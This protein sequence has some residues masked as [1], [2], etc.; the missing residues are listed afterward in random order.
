MEH[1]KRKSVVKINDVKDE[2]L[3]A[4]VSIEKTDEIGLN[5][6]IRNAKN[7]KEAVAVIRKCEELSKKQDK[8]I[9]NIVEKQ[10]EL[11]KEF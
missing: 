1:N 9:I 8:R 4:L 3:D 7:R 6:A 2:L 10:E 5:D 11:L